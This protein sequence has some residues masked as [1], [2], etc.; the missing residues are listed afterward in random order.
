VSFLIFDRFLCFWSTGWWGNLLW[1]S[2]FFLITWCNHVILNVIINKTKFSACKVWIH[3]FYRKQMHC[4]LIALSCI[5]FVNG[6]NGAWLQLPK[7]IDF[8]L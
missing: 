1:V 7:S 6:I 3:N 8:G 5:I 4:V 2:S